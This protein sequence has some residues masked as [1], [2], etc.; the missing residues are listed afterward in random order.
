[1]LVALTGGIASGKSTVARRLAELGAVVVDADVIAR[2]VV[3][4]GTPGLARIA[5]EFGPGVIA[6]DGTLDRAALGAIIFGDE[7]ARATLNAITHPAVGERSRALFAE[8]LA[9]DPDALVV[10]DVPLLVNERGEG[11]ADEFDR[12]IVVSADEETRVRRLV[13]LRGLDE[14]DARRRVGAQAP[15]S[16]RL[17]IA[18]IVI[19]ANGTLDQ[20][21]AQVDEAW[22]SLRTVRGRA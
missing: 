18:D 21:L 2:E 10:Y 6:P 19:D 20:T 7:A 13:E 16:A 5:E 3:E 1:M 12:V 4:P 11:R 14:A 17:A 22:A 15:E 9:A 8:A